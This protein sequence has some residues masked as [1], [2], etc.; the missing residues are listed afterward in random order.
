MSTL[1][2]AGQ[3]ACVSVNTSS[4]RTFSVD[5][6]SQSPVNAETTDSRDPR[7]WDYKPDNEGHRFATEVGQEATWE[8]ALTRCWEEIVLPINNQALVAYGTFNSVSYEGASPN[9]AI[10]PGTQILSSPVSSIGSR[11]L[12]E[13]ISESGASVLLASS[14]S[15]A[16]GNPSRPEL[17]ASSQSRDGVKTTTTRTVVSDGP[18][19]P[20]TVVETLETT[21]AT[22]QNGGSKKR[23]SYTNLLFC[24]T[25][26]MCLS[27]V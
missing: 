12:S 3:L 13:G 27:W 10:S 1:N 19:G 8:P 23:A 14:P 6:Y 4:A 24:W 17:S 22:T 25:A 21:T 9:S 7:G 5:Y 2:S 16:T 20:T 15:T 26:A 18:G 11:T